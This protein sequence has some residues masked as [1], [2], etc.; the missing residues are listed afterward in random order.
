M[1]WAISMSLVVASAETLPPPPVPT[2]TESVG[3]GHWGILL[4][5]SL[6]SF[7]ISAWWLWHLVLVQFFGEIPNTESD[8]ATRRRS[9]LD[10]L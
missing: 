7:F 5:C 8:Y 9:R 6:I 10:W 4:K 1:K 3:V 2:Y